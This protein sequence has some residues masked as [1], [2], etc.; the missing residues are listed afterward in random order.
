MKTMVSEPIDYVKEETKK[1]VRY[2]YFNT[3]GF[4]C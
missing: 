2:P 1:A 3:A 4:W